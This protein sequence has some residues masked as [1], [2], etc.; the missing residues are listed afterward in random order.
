MQR[1]ETMSDKIP[2]PE[3]PIE[4]DLTHFDEPPQEIKQMLS[5]YLLS[6]QSEQRFISGTDKIAEKITE[7]HIGK[8]IDI[9]EKED[10]RSFKAFKFGRI[11]GLIIFMVSLAFAFVLLLVFKDSEYFPTILTA[12][13]SF[14]GGLGVGKFIV[15]N[16]DKK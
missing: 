7:E 5:S 10:E 11:V 9:S 12:I 2:A 16:S 6:I 14:L 3:N 13:F 4:N 1:S 8:I 15:P